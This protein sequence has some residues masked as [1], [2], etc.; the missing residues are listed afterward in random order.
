M[1]GGGEPDYVGNVV[2]AIKKLKKDDVDDE[3]KKYL[4]YVV[5]KLEEIVDARPKPVEDPNDH[6][7]CGCY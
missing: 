3:L 4:Y 2:E 7:E 6:C 5:K 1:C